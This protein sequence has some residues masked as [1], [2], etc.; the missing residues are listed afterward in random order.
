MDIAIEDAVW[1][2]RNPAFAL[3]LDAVGWTGGQVRSQLVDF[4]HGR[5][6]CV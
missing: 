2:F 4:V 1:I 5:A 3:R 6:N